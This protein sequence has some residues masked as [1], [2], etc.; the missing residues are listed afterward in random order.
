MSNVDGARDIMAPK[1]LILNPPKN[2][3]PQP[4]P[5]IRF[6]NVQRDHPPPG[7]TIDEEARR[8]QDEHVRAASQVQAFG[9][10]ND[11]PVRMPQ[12]VV[13]SRDSPQVTTAPVANVIVGSKR[14]ASVAS[15]GGADDKGNLQRQSHER[16]VSQDAQQSR[17]LSENQ[18]LIQQTP[19]VPPM[20]PPPMIPQQSHPIQATQPPPPSRPTYQAPTAFDRI[21]RD[22]G[23]GKVVTTK[24]V[25]RMLIVLKMLQMLCINASGSRHVLAFAILTRG[26]CYSTLHPPSLSME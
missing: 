21:E 13:A 11:T 26:Q 7:I 5:R 18:S 16:D 8:R 22:A 10:T 4:T 1:K 24:C 2:P 6:T 19:S 3:A 15:L 17:R 23:K 9:R 20:Q 14:S 12:R 25:N